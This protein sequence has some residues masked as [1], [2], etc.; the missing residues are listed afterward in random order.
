MG[1][2]RSPA[3]KVAADRVV[4]GQGPGTVSSRRSTAPRRATTARRKGR[5]YRSACPRR[6][7]RSRAWTAASDVVPG[8]APASSSA[9]SRRRT[10]PP[11]A[12]ASHAGDLRNQKNAIYVADCARNDVR[13]MEGENKRR[14][15]S[16]SR[17][18]A[19]RLRWR[20][21]RPDPVSP[22][23]RDIPVEIRL[24]PNRPTPTTPEETPSSPTDR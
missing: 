4:C 3:P 6:E 10:P 18:H 20:N 11:T 19:V 1:S 16:P 21:R 7:D 5:Q 12:G 17:K 8:R 9:P 15:S 2:V 14:I 23:R 22:Y 24:N 13:S